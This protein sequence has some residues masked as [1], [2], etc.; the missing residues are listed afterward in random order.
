MILV[1]V[2]GEIEEKQAKKLKASI[3]EIFAGDASM[4][5]FWTS[6]PETFEGEVEKVWDET[7]DAVQD[8]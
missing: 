5:W 4:S 1:R 6:C 3:K 7:M 8:Q 2:D